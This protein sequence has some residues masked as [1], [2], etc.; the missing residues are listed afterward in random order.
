MVEINVRLSSVMSRYNKVEAEMP[1]EVFENLADDVYELMS[2]VDPFLSSHGNKLFLALSCES[3][4]FV[5]A[6]WEALLPLSDLMEKYPT[7]RLEAIE[8]EVGDYENS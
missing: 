1:D 3:A 5:E 8:E 4:S 6:C 2:D 7:L